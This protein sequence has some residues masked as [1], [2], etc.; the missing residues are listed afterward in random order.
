VVAAVGA[1]GS[2]KTRLTRDLEAWLGSKIVVRHVYFGQPKSGLVFKLLNKPGSMARA[3]GGGPGSLVGYI[4]AAKWLWLAR[5]RRRLA[6]R[7][8]MA[9]KRGE[10]VIAERYPLHDFHSMA[11]PMDGPRLQP[12]GHFAGFEM[13]QYRAIEQPD[14]TLVLETSLET[15]RERKIDLPLEEHIPKVEAVADLED[16]PGRLRID[17]ARPYEEVLLAAKQAVWKALNEGH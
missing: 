6:L 11:A 15:L 10:L 7:A 5:R 12:D 4:E 9:A 3:R 2:G 1:D 13:A 17:V 8:R 14:V 16:V